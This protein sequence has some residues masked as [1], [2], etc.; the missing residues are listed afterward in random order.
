MKECIDDPI[1]ARIAEISEARGMPA[2][3]IGGYVR[4]CLLGRTSK[5][6][7]VVVVGSGIELAKEVAASLDKKIKVTIF[8]NFGTANFRYK[9]RE[10]EFVGARKESYRHDSR[11][12]V[13]ENGTLEDDQK[14]RDFTI[15]AIA[16]SLNA[17]DYGQMFDPFGGIDDLRARR[18]RTPLDPGT[19]FSDDPL[20]MIRAIRFAAQLDFLIEEST[21]ESIGHN[22]E[23]IDILSRERIAEELNKIL[24]TTKPSKGLKL[25]ERTGLLALFLPEVAALKGVDSME[26]RMHKDNFYHSLEVLDNICHKT[27]NLWLRWAALIHDI[28]KPVTKRY[29]VD[30]GWTFHGHDFIGSKMVS[31][32]F[33]KLKLPL[34]EKMKYVQKLVLLHLLPIVLSQENITDSAVRRLLFEAGEEIDDLMMLCEADITSKNDE[35]KKKYLGNFRLVRRKLNEIEEKDKVRN[36]QPPV[37]GDDII[38]TF[39]ISPGRHVGTIKTAIKDAILDGIIGNNREEAY[40][41]MLTRG[42]ELGLNVVKDLRKA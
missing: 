9:G 29:A 31:D 30:T 40:E 22:R 25:L 19:T 14:R 17:T 5:D 38:E 16:I 21:L 1:F 33:R 8:K 15:N 3:V 2:Y 36:F 13:V 4:D 32:L 7:D 28:G 39:G 23:R 10:I 11:N 26:G 37:S 34:N 35:L 42:K 24:M 12:P 41:F 27:N 20:R 6:V 18:I